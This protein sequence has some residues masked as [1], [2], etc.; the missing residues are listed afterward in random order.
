MSSVIGY[1][2]RPL[3]PEATVKDFLYD[4]PMHTFYETFEEAT[5]AAFEVARKKCDRTGRSMIS[6]I[7]SRSE[8]ACNVDGHT[9]VFRISNEYY[10]E[11]IVVFAL[12][13][14]KK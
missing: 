3:D 8:N 7:T 6:V 12:Y 10:S 5:K 9:S 1:L 13:G 4:R 14:T 11:D 2:V